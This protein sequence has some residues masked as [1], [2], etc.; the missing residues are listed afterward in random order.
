MNFL[1]VKTEKQDRLFYIILAR[2]E[3]KNALN[4]T[5]VTELTHALQLATDDDEVKIII[6]KAEGDVFSAGA[7]LE[8]LQRLQNFSYEENLA[9]S[10]LLKTLLLKIYTHPKIVIAQVEGH[11]IAG[12]CGLAAVCDFCFSVPDAKFGYTEVKIGFIPALVMVF[13]LR[14]INGAKARELL[15]TGKLVTAAEALSYG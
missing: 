1:F 14:K 7:D 3:K 15:F 13:L 11:A 12:G 4:D 10:T 6:L 8:Y 5:V 9:D 2:P